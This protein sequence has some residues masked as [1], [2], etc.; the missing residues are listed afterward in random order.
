MSPAQTQN[1]PIEN[2]E[3]K[4]ALE[5]LLFITDHPL[6]L[7]DLAKITGV[8]DQERLKGLIAELQAKLDQ[9]GSAVQLLE[10]ADGF[11]MGTRPSYAPFVRKLFAERMTMRLP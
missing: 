2:E 5:S 9:D 6:S 1:P 10:V 11:Q 8:K 4:K 7:S 3:L